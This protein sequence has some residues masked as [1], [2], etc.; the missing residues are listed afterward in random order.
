MQACF[1]L[2]GYIATVISVT[3]DSCRPVILTALVVIATII[4]VTV[5]SCRPVTL[6]TLV[7]IATI[8]SV[9]VDSCRHVSCYS[10]SGYCCY[11]LC[12]C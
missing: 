12:N 8:I 9:T 3:V 6:T 10:L 1:S 4:S 11:N 7:V 5:D 2:S